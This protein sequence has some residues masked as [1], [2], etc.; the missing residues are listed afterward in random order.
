M[1]VLPAGVIPPNPAELLDSPLLKIAIE[2]LSSK[3]DYVILDTPPVGMVADS[4]VIGKLANVTMF[5]TRLQ[6][7]PKTTFRL[8]NDLSNKKLPNCNLVVNSVGTKH[9][10]YGKYGYSYTYGSGKYGHYGLYGNYGQGEDKQ[11]HV[12]K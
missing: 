5:V 2:Y 6:Y 8:L 1:D 3:Y 12:E 7:S 11:F 10:R 4:L 9:G